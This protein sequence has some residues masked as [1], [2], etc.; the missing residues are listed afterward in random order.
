MPGMSSKKPNR[1]P[2]RPQGKRQTAPLYARVDPRLADAF[3]GHVD[4]LRPKTSAS[5]VIEMLIEQF[6]SEAGKWPPQP[7]SSEQGGSE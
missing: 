2:G 3:N 4:T 6:L 7:L 5:A 1:K